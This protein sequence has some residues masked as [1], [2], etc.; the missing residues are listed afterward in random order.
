[1][2]DTP[3]QFSPEFSPKFRSSREISRIDAQH[4]WHPYAAPGEPTRVV[5]STDG[6]YLELADAVTTAAPGPAVEASADSESAAQPDSQWVIDGMS[7]WW[8]ACFGHSHPRLVEAAKN[9]IDA[10]S[11]VMFGGLTHQPAAQLTEN[12]LALTENRYQQVFYSDSGSVAVEVAIK[13]A[14]QYARGASPAADGETSR[15]KLLTWRSGYH[16]DTFQ[17][18]SVCDPDGGMHSLWNG[19]VKEQIFVPAPPTRGASAQE[20]EEYLQVVEDAMNGEVAAMII[21][22][23]VQGA[24]GMRFHD[25][26]L[27]V[28]I[29][30]L[31][32]KH[33]IVLIADE[34]AT[35][36]GRTGEVF[37]THAA[38]IT[39]DILCVGKA[40]TGGFMSLAAT[41]ATKEVA[42]TMQPAAL[43]HGPTFMAN[44][45][46]CAVA[47]EATAMIREGEWRSDVARIES[48]LVAGLQ[49][50]RDKPG[51]A[52]VRVLGAIGVVEMDAD[53]DMAQATAAALSAGVWLRPFGR[54]VY[55]M[56]P[57]ICNDGELAAICQAIARVVE[58]CG[59]YSTRGTGDAHGTRG[60]HDTEAQT[61]QLTDTTPATTPTKPVTPTTPATPEETA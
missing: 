17:A 23:V 60:D 50:L 30:E 41:L 9:Q 46:A 47:T 58:V 5:R 13:M 18:M 45:L 43:M 49:P 14:L 12:L 8:A 48:A 33:G 29:R 38:G 19:T 42:E 24:G 40:L 57:Y 3:A 56:P 44:P 53:V 31:C 54:L 22:P 52:D 16:G 51:V 27:L 37:T 15:N 39:P 28:G 25:H 35:G 26:E 10:M 61:T 2:P 20:R 6:C 32:S 21:E 1:M 4:I 59:T 7:S 11:H 55:T 36:F 34:I